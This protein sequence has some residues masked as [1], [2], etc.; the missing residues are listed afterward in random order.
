VPGYDPWADGDTLDRSAGASVD[1]VARILAAHPEIGCLVAEPVLAGPS[2]PPHGYWSQIRALCDAHRVLLLFDEIPRGLGRTGRLFASEH[3]GVRP[4]ATVLGKA[5]GG[6][7]VPLAAVI[8][9]ADLNV[10][11]DL[12]IGH[13]THEKSA[14][15]SVVALE[16]LAVL[17]QENLVARA[18]AI[19]ARL[20]AAIAADAGPSRPITRV[21]A[22]GAMVALA[23]EDRRADATATRVEAL[24]R[25]GV[26]LTAAAGR[27]LLM[28][29]LVMTDAQIDDVAARIVR[30]ADRG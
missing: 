21:A 16:V 7:L 6:A 25:E 26:N 3:T 18:G 9:R 5:L 27:A 17:E 20:A 14:L 11:G 15:G 22:I 30:G 8:A 2:L 29:P 13:F 28:P 23:F 12:A 19:G 4:D 24:Y 10:A 1:A